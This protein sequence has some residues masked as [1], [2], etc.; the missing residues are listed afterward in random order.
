[1]D[2]QLVVRVLSEIAETASETLELQEVFNR[3][4][5]SVR[6]LIPFE[7]MGV[8]RI[9]DGQ[10]AVKHATTLDCSEHESACSEPMLLTAW[11]PRLRPRPGPI[12]RIDDAH[13]ELDADFR[14]D[15][16]ILAGGVRSAL[17]EPF[18]SQGAFGGGVWLSSYEPRVF[19]ADH[20][21]IL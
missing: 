16:D 21:E 11:S 17:W 14:V 4:A 15:A 5:A 19:T 10:W 13:E 9:V 12:A 20:Q 2:S 18:R 6:R 3:V 1:M 7:H 8:V